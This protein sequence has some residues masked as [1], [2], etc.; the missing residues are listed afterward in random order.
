MTGYLE[1]LGKKKHEKILHVDS[2]S[3]MLL[4]R[5]PVYHSTTKYRR[6]HH[7]TCGLVEDGDV[8]GEDRGCKESSKHVD[9]MC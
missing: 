8:F 6:R 9:K 7:F 4:V 1:E 5:N 2:Q 3:V